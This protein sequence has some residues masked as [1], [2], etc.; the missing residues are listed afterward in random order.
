MD[1]SKREWWIKIEDKEEGPLIEE[2]FQEKLRAGKIPLMA[3]V[4]S[5]QMNDWEPLLTYIS[6]DESFRR[7]STMPPV[8]Q[9]ESKSDS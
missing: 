7:P 3:L 9:D 8:E 1:I 6:S 5:N 4:K 2:A